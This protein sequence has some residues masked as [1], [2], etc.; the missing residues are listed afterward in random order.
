VG[1]TITVDYDPIE[2]KVTFRRKGGEES[3]TIEFEVKDDDELHLCSLF[4]YN[5]DEIEYLG[6]D[7]E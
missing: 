4:Y 6:Y 3:H 7:E 2:N 1:D 5:N